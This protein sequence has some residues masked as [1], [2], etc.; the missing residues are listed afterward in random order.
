[1]FCPEVTGIQLELIQEQARLL[2]GVTPTAKT[3]Q[4]HSG[5]L[6]G[7]GLLLRGSII[8]GSTL[9]EK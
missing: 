8:G 9:V 3:T 7:G 6:C 1:M 4:I 2:L 5:L